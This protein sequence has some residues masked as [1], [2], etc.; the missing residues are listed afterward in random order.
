[1]STFPPGSPSPGVNSI[2]LPLCLGGGVMAGWGGQLASSGLGLCQGLEGALGRQ[3]SLCGGVLIP[4]HWHKGSSGEREENPV[5]VRGQQRGQADSRPPWAKQQLVLGQQRDGCG[6]EH[7]EPVGPAADFQTDAGTPAGDGPSQRE[8]SESWRYF[9]DHPG[10]ARLRPMFSSCSRRRHP[11][12]LGGQSSLDW[13][14][15]Q[16]G[17]LLL[18]GGGE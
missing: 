8:G 11:H 18:P 15:Q 12:L 17:S 16:L 3:R 7:P 6:G 13:L 9:H 4:P 10:C 1:M 14:P 2:P 5:N